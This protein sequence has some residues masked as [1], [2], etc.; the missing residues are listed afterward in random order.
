MSD[1]HAPRRR[2]VEATARRLSAELQAI[3]VVV[4]R[5]P[6]PDT[7]YLEQDEFKERLAA[8]KRG[9]FD[10]VGVRAEAEVRIRDTDQMLASAGLWGIESDAD[11]EDEIVDIAIE[12]WTQLRKVLKAIGIAAAELP[13]ELD[14]RWIEWR[15]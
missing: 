7:S 14:R 6:D 1:S 12:E 9:E 11:S 8:Y 10:F 3:R 13:T 15:T 4:E 2:V 5:D